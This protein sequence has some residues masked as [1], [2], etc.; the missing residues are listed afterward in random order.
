M[1]EVARIISTAAFTGIA[2]DSAFHGVNSRR[3]PLA[4]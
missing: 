2:L 1:G 4:Q 3:E